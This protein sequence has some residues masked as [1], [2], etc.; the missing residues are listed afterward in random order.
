MI[1]IKPNSSEKIT[2]SMYGWYTI[3]VFGSHNST[4][5][6]TYTTGNSLDYFKVFPN[7][8]YDFDLEENGVVYLEYL[9]FSEESF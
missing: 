1:L 4:F 9:H 2:G 3:G 6:L 5:Q 7:S 8:P